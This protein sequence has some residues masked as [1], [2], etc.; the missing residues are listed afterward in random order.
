MGYAQ[1]KV[2]CEYGRHQPLSQDELRKPSD[3]PGPQNEYATTVRPR[4]LTTSL[5]SQ[6]QF[7]LKGPFLSR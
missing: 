2:M 7:S 1:H 6:K 5:V 3:K 4:Y